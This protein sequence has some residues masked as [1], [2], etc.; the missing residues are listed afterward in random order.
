MLGSKTGT[1]SSNVFLEDGVVHR[2]SNDS[3]EGNIVSKK[4]YVTI[5][6]YFVYNI[7]NVDDEEKWTQH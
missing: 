4:V 6:M 7:I 5:R 1:N 3:V 2:S